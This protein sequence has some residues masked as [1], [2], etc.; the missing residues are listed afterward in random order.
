MP[1]PS[2]R[3][4]CKFGEVVQGSPECTTCGNTPHSN[5][6]LLGV[7]E[8]MAVYR[9]VYEVRPI[10]PHRPYA[11]RL[12]AGMRDLCVRCGGRTVL[13][14]GDGSAWR[15]CPTCEGTGGVWNRP[16]EEVE[17]ARQQ[18]IARWPSAAMEERSR[19]RL[20][21]AVARTGA[22]RR[23]RYSS[24]ALRFSDVERAFGEAE[25]LL[26]TNWR[27]KGRGHCRRASLDPRYSNHALRGAARSW[28]LIRPHHALGWKR[29]LPLAI[30]EKA[31][32][33]LGVPARLLM[34]R[35]F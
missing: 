14:V 19:P 8:A 15:R 22:R 27:L 23:K 3:H 1:H 33:V 11:D 32:E 12:F 31:A 24:H 16:V 7:W 10:G 5:G 18:F 34:S 6:W 21:R 2:W 13:T 26:G 29:L 28:G 30:I 20:L 17:A 25:R 4:V 35:E 9:Y